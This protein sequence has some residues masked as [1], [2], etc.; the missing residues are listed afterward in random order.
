[1][2]HTYSSRAS[3][4]SRL[5]LLGLLALGLAPTAVQAQAPTWSFAR[6]FKKTTSPQG[7][8]I[9][10]ATV[11]NAAGD[12][13]MAGEF[14]GTVSF[15]NTTLTSQ[16]TG[17]DRDDLFI[18]KWSR[19]TNSFVWAQRLGSLTNDVATTIALGPDGIYLAGTCGT[20]ATLGN[21]TV[22]EEG[23]FL[24]RVTDTSTGATV[25]WAQH[26]PV[27]GI[28]NLAVSGAN[29]Y[30]VGYLKGTVTIA[31]QTLTNDGGYLLRL[32]DTGM[33]A[34]PNW[35]R[36]L[37]ASARGVAAS[38]S[39]VYV[40]GHFGGQATFGAT[41]LTSNSNFNGYVVKLTDSG[42]APSFTWV[43][44]IGGPGN[45]YANVVAVGG[46]NVYVGG[47]FYGSSL[48]GNQTLTTKNYTNGDGF[49]TKLV[50]AGASS[51]F[52]WSM[53]LGNGYKDEV[54]KLVVQG[55][56]VYVAGPT[57]MGNGA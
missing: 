38:G 40:S 15:G 34:T 36:G 27:G 16:G 42:T 24:A 29:L 55:P 32:T 10:T 28:G 26:L 33:A 1:M 43:Q 37:G 8:A 25:N 23:Q 35:F 19:T 52:V 12:V 22:A 9:A 21:T 18:A 13:Y 46:A 4:P 50:D 2:Q 45:A 39:N 6:S 54:Q 17:V 30:A 57:G 49:V 20:G 31:G 7:E 41:T 48:I 11:V 3:W 5:F 14:A 44:Q 51:S 47:E 53:P 56:A